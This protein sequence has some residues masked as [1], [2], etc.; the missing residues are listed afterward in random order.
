MDFPRRRAELLAT[1]SSEGRATYEVLRAQL[2]RDVDRCFA[3]S[4]ARLEKGMEAA[5]GD[6]HTKLDRTIGDLRQKVRSDHGRRCAP[7]AAASTATAPA[8]STSAGSHVFPDP[9]HGPDL[10]S[11]TSSTTNTAR[12]MRV[13]SSSIT[14]DGSHE[15]EVAA[16]SSDPAPAAAAT[17]ISVWSA[18]AV[19]PAS[20]GV[21][22]LVASATTRSTSPGGDIDA[23]PDANPLVS[24]GP[25][26]MPAST[27]QSEPDHVRETPITCSTLGLYPVANAIQINKV[28]LPE[29]AVSPTRSAAFSTSTF[30]AAVSASLDSEL[31][32]ATP[33]MCSTECPG[34]ENSETRTTP[35]CT[36]APPASSTS[37]IPAMCEVSIEVNSMALMDITSSSPILTKVTTTQA[38]SPTKCSTEGLNGETSVAC[39]KYLV[40]SHHQ[41][42]QHVWFAEFK[43]EL[44]K[45]REELLAARKEMNSVS[46]LTIRFL[47]QCVPGYG[48]LTLSWDPGQH[49]V[50]SA[51]TI[52]DQGIRAI[53]HQQLSVHTRLQIAWSVVWE[54]SCVGSRRTAVS[55]LFDSAG[56]LAVVLF[57]TR[58]SVLAYC[59]ANIVPFSDPVESDSTPQIIEM[60]LA[61]RIFSHKTAPAVSKQKEVCQNLR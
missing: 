29:I 38:L 42:Q 49:A 34:E 56:G 27:M 16:S 55:F 59:V 26:G 19:A 58:C 51:A 23:A 43:T 6:L 2:A 54:F 53:C 25:I 20:G 13:S 61:T 24:T 31:A 18:T 32:L 14:T 11:S 45:S 21:P 41:L 50:D 3:E 36:A 35:T 1:L 22:S 5:L 57:S 60:R 47:F 7:A 40:S 48:L 28:P 30:M 4:K 10:S 8:M 9:N 17:S 37:A 39:L 33:T 46:L 12:P 15:L 44:R 52:C